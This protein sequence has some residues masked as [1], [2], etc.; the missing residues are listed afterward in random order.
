METENKSPKFFQFFLNLHRIP[1]RKNRCA[2]PHLAN[3]LFVPY[4]M[5]RSVSNIQ[6]LM[7]EIKNKQKRTTAPQ[8]LFQATPEIPKRISKITMFICRA[9]YD[10]YYRLWMD[11]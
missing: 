6:V 11:D 7:R 9:F 4:R 8:L 10:R 1:K 2:A 5:V 3:S